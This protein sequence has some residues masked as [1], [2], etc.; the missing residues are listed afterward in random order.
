MMETKEQVQRENTKL[1]MKIAKVKRQLK[2]LNRQTGPNSSDY[3]NLTLQLN[4]LMNEYV[5]EEISILEREENRNLVRDSHR[6]V[7][8]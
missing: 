8:V 7:N 1:L 3:I 6:L 4:S 5:E 2:E